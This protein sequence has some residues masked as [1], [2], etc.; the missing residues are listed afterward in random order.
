MNMTFLILLFAKV[1]IGLGSEIEDHSAWIPHASRKALG[2]DEVPLKIGALEFKC[3]PPGS[4]KNLLNNEFHY[5]FEMA[6]EAAENFNVDNR[7]VKAFWPNHPDAVW[8]KYTSEDFL[9]RAKQFYTCLAGAARGQEL[10]KCGNM[11]PITVTCDQDQRCSNADV[12]SHEVLA[13][14]DFPTRTINL[15]KSWFNQR[16]TSDVICVSGE[17]LKKYES[18]GRCDL[19]LAWPHHCVRYDGQHL[20]KLTRDPQL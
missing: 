9:N 3:E 8:Q 19:V 13:H 18:K 17:S 11:Y 12:Q 2:V 7:Y 20:P 10:E 6:S 4:N 1:L 14:T 15:C 5:A 16:D